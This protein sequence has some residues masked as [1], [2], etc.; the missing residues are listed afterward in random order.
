[1]M[2]SSKTEKEKCIIQDCIMQ[3][4]KAETK[5]IHANRCIIYN[6]NGKEK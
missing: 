3:N 1:M 6:K 4:L 5:T 2:E